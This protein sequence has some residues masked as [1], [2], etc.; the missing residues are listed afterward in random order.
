MS[1]KDDFAEFLTE[2]VTI[3]HYLGNNG[4]EDTFDTAIAYKCEIQDKVTQVNKEDGTIFVSTTQIFLDGAVQVGE[5]DRIEFNGK[6]P[7]IQAVQIDHEFGVP[8]ASTL[9]F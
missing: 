4:Y 6:S 9:F 7:I 8:Y 2:D 5:K 3:A 1:L